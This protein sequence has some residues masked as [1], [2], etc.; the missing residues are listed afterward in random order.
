MTKIEEGGDAAALL[1]TM[2]A[3]I[4]PLSAASA[5]IPAGQIPQLKQN[6]FEQAGGKGKYTD[7]EKSNKA[8]R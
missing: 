4:V 5:G 3:N 8:P 2:E 7:P 6:A 1:A